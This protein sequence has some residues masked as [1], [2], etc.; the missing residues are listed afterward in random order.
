MSRS[1]PLA[2]TEIAR[3]A[4]VAGQL[5]VRA[6]DQIVDFTETMVQLG[7][8]TNLSA[9]QAAVAFARFTNIMGVS[10]RETPRL[11]AALVELGNNLATT[12]S[13][14]LTMSLRLGAAGNALG[15][16]AEETLAFAGALSSLGIRA[17]LGGSTLSRVFLE[18]A[19]AVA[20][21]GPKL[22]TFA[23]VAGLTADEFARLV[24]SNPTEAILQFAQGL[25]NVEGGLSAVVQVL[26][27]TDLNSIRLRQTLIGLA[28]GTETLEKALGLV[29]DEASF[30]GA[31][32]E[33]YGRFAET[34]AARIEILKNRVTSLGIAFGTPLLGG[35]VAILDGIGDALIHLGTALAPLGSQ[36]ADLEMVTLMATGFSQIR[37]LE[38]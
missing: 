31:L 19:D 38:P 7:T 5:G 35:A 23:Q 33:E 3:V 27:D 14:I 26:K 24:Q 28:S 34:T 10:L 8:A 30:G 17:E 1:M 29:S 16:S 13:E 6:A 25:G 2:A 4:S 32:V 12:E 18:I 9:D 21:P 20:Q 37:R 15:I 11:G 36:V 22:D